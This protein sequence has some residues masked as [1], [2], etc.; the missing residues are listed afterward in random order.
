MTGGARTWRCSDPTPATATPP[1]LPS[2]GQVRTR[3]STRLHGGVF[4]EGIISFGERAG[5]QADGRTD[6]RE[7]HAHRH[8][9][10]GDGRGGEDD[11]L[12]V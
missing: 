2:P 8:H 6:G 9:T 12:K 11:A 3:K 4:D 5:A 7:T 10:D 1:P